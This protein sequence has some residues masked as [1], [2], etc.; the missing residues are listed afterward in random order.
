MDSK[1]YWAIVVRFQ[2]GC[3]VLLMFAFDVISCAPLRI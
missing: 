1:L 2:V 3:F